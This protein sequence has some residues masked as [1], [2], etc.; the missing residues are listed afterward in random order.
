[1][2]L[3]KSKALIA[4]NDKDYADACEAYFGSSAQA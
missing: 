4:S 3:S 2:P 1:M